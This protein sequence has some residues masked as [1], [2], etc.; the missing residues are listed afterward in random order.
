MSKLSEIVESIKQNET[1]KNADFS[2]PKYART[3]FALESKK[4]AAAD[5]IAN[6]EQEYAKQIFDHALLIGI[7]GP[8]E[9]TKQFCALVSSMEEGVGVDGN[10]MYDRIAGPLEQRLGARRDLSVNLVAQMLEDLRSVVEELPNLRVARFQLNTSLPTLKTYG[11]VRRWVKAQVEEKAGKI[12]N[13]LFLKKEI[14]QAALK[15]QF[16]GDVLPVAISCERGDFENLTPSFGKG[17][18]YYQIE[19]NDDITPD[20]VYK[21]FAETKSKFKPAKK[22]RKEKDKE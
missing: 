19:E 22:N 16:D 18:V 13:I 5:T 2:D 15:M 12:I 4:R 8:E 20:F 9:K 3:R 10:K 1:V 11:E 6:L 14:T 21:V 7:G 17:S